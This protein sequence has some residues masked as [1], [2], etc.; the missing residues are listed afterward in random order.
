MIQELIDNAEYTVHHIGVTDGEST[1]S[2]YKVGIKTLE[3]I[4]KQEKWTD[5]HYYR[6]WNGEIIETN[7]DGDIWVSVKEKDFNKELKKEYVDAIK[8]KFKKGLEKAHKVLPD[9]C[10][11]TDLYNPS[12]ILYNEVDKV[13][14]IKFGFIPNG[15][16]PLY[17]Q[18]EEFYATMDFLANNKKA[19]IITQ[20]IINT[21]VN[22]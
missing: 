3:G 9:T 8:L 16:R 21:W 6:Y 4:Y 12:F 10:I 11:I 1:C 7:C 5:V 15:N 17:T 22:L 19:S 13:Y 18:D 20:E 2:L 14:Y